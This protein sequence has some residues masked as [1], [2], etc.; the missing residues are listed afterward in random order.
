[1]Y[2]FYDESGPVIYIEDKTVMYNI[3]VQIDDIIQKQAK[4]IKKLIK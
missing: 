2:C 3:L 4:E 1:M